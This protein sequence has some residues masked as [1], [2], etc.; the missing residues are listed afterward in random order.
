M[1]RGELLF[2]VEVR[3]YTSQVLVAVKETK[4]IY[5]ALNVSGYTDMKGV[6]S[7]WKDQI[8]NLRWVKN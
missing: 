4:R 5:R 2:S 7:Y 3:Q 6:K 1:L 8:L